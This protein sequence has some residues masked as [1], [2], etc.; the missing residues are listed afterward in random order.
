MSGSSQITVSRPRLWR[1]CLST[2]RIY[3]DG[4]RRALLWNG[5]TKSFLVEPGQ[6]HITCVVARNLT[7]RKIDF[8]A[9]GRPIAFEAI[10]QSS[11]PSGV[12]PHIL[13]ND[14]VLLRQ[15]D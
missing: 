5:Q 12:L 11:V 1:D 9:K 4:K 13:D 15:V 3:V 10:P 6:H 2:F 14:Y 7:S 8:C